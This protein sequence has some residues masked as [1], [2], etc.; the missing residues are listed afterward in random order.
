MSLQAEIFKDTYSYLENN[1]QD[2]FYCEDFS[3]NHSKELYALLSKKYDQ[4]L[5]IELRFEIRRAFKSYFELL[6]QKISIFF[7]GTQLIILKDLQKQIFGEYSKQ[8]H[9]I[10]QKL[11]FLSD[12]IENYKLSNGLYLITKETLNEVGADLE[13][14]DDSFLQKELYKKAIKTVLKLESRDIVFSM[15]E[16]L[17]IKKFVDP[18]SIT[19]PREQNIE[20]RSAGLPKEELERIKN[21]V[22]EKNISEEI[23]KSMQTLMERKLNFSRINNE[24]FIK[25]ALLFIQEEL[26][27]LVSMYISEDEDMPLKKAFANYI[28]RE[29]FKNIYELFAENLLELHA[30]RDKN[31]EAFLKYYDGNTELKNERHIIKPEIIDENRDKWNALSILPITI[32]KQKNDKEMALLVEKMKSVEEKI[33]LLREKIETLGNKEASLTK[34]E[35]ELN[36][37]MNATISESQKLQD[38]N[39][40]LKTKRKKASK[41]S[42]EELQ[43]QINS[44]VLEIKMLGRQEEELRSAIR[45]I[46]SSIDATRIKS[47]NVNTEIYTQERLLNQ[48]LGKKEQLRKQHEPT[49][50]KYHIIIV[51]VAKVLMPKS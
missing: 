6:N 42:S 13:D 50:E 16:N 44:V 32:Q 49:L 45:E 40:L 29:N 14:I 34:E 48:H 26:Y 33:A 28:L 23:Q 20:R 37:K 15:N 39:V 2:G 11:S 9:Q 10:T 21:M 3:K 1:L 30:M 41:D 47:A 12:D 35:E 27:K 8:F 25:N 18:K 24:Y 43:E 19:S 46:Q 36:E 31:V 4:E 17:A 5:I 51:A 22:F 7:Q 38:H